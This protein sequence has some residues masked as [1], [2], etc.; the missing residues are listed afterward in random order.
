ML[1]S[2]LNCTV[3]KESLSQRAHRVCE[4]AFC[5]DD[6]EVM[7]TL[8]MQRPQFSQRLIRQPGVRQAASLGDKGTPGSKTGCRSAAAELAAAYR[9][10]G[11]ASS[12]EST[13]SRDGAFHAPPPPCPVPAAAAWQSWRSF[14]AALARGGDACSCTDR[15][16]S[17]DCTVHCTV[18]LAL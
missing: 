1:A 11:R 3:R 18:A 6:F 14:R 4:Y 15:W 17:A 7:I 8:V 13:T 9:A 5:S 12:H 2:G 10:R 16:H